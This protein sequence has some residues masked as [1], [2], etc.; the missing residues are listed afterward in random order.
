MKTQMNNRSQKIKRENLQEG[1]ENKQ[2][3]SRSQKRRKL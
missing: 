1:K 3:E 2:M